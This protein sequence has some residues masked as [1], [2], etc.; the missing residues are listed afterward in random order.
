MMLDFIELFNTV[1]GFFITVAY[2]YQFFFLAYGL[3]N[4][5]RKKTKQSDTLNK[6]GVIICAR[7]ESNVIA[8]L[9][10]SLKKQNYPSDLIDIYVVADNCTDNTAQIARESGAFV[11]ERF[12]KIQ[13]GKGYAMD[14]FFRRLM[15]SDKLKDYAGFFVFDADNIVDKNFV[16]EMNNT[17]NSGEYSAITSYRNSKNFASNWISAGYALWFLRES[18]FLNFPRHLLGTNC[19]ISGTGFLIS[20]KVV[21]ANNGWP[22]HLL[23]EDIEFSVN[24]AIEGQ[25]IGYCDS[26]V[27]YDEQP[28]RFSQSW[29]Q[30][31]RW[32]KGFYQVDSKYGA[33][34][35][36]RCFGGK[37]R[38]S[39]YDML[40]TVAPSMLMTIIAVFFNALV[41]MS[42][43]TMTAYRAKILLNETTS[44]MLSS[45]FSYFMVLLLY[46]A[47]TTVCEWKNIHAPAY[48]KILSVFTF[49]V[50][51]FTYLPISLCAFVKKVE[52]KPIQHGYV[53]TVKNF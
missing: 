15:N 32:S 19:A 3:I 40:M 28:T 35:T 1:L 23:T 10:A 4:K 47:V 30:R 13:V 22:F 37:R 52:W 17:F 41:S 43:L 29:R 20:T 53:K 2:A 5:K 42:A 9:I 8:D 31:L 21:E 33:K 24:C 18:R 36:K 26:A 48:K 11:Y 51:M 34:L 38:F 12:N 6:Y 27:I 49:P 14:Y 7:N 45:I 46:G 39:C 50:F 16:R 25:K 44:F